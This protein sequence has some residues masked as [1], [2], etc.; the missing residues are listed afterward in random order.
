MF[1]DVH[2]LIEH[3]RKKITV[4]ETVI[5]YFKLWKSLRKEF[6]DNEESEAFLQAI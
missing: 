3:K 1:L 6:G 5:F 2:S 4:A